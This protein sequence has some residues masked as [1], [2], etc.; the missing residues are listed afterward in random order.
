MTVIAI[1][2]I[3]IPAIIIIIEKYKQLRKHFRLKYV[4]NFEKELKNAKRKP[5]KPKKITDGEK[6]YL[7]LSEN[8]K[9]IYMPNNAKHV[10]VCGTTGSGKTVALSNFI[11]S[12]TDNN[13]PMLI[14]DGKG[15]LGKDSLLYITKKFCANRKKYIIDFNNPYTSDKYNPFKNANPSMI[16]DMLIN[17][18]D[19]SEEHYKLN[20]ERYL[21]RLIN[22]LYKTNIPLSFKSIIKYIPT[23]EFIRLSGELA[24]QGVITRAEHNENINVAN[25]SGEIAK[26]ASARFGTIAESEIGTIF[27]GTGIDIYTAL[28]QNAII[29]FV[30]NPLMYPEMSPL[31]GRLILIDSKQAVQ[32]LFGN[33]QRTF[34]IFDEINSYASTALLDLVNKSRSANVTC[35][36]ATQSLSDLDFANGEFFKEQIIENCNNYIVLRQNSATN[37]E[38]WANILGTRKN[39]DV[40]YQLGRDKQGFAKDTGVG[41]A[42]PV[43]EFLYHPDDIKTLK[44]GNAILLSKDNGFHSKVII[45]K[46]F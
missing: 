14:L 26:S 23:N 1:A 10:F 46:P 8:G 20:T 17:M 34:F 19:W 12:G 4:Y 29:L 21:Q 2:C 16:K 36:L 28:K 32:K 25:I 43:R 45:D 42:R 41:S 7:G 9:E 13:Y 35:I 3:G 31:I 15:D 38:N 30:L 24:K 37:A 44:T 39:L 27:D 33:L 18:T 5:Y 22:L 11:K 40:T 6:T